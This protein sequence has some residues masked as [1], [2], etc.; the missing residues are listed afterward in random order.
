M[1]SIYTENKNGQFAL[2]NEMR[3]VWEQHVY[4]TRMLLISIAD[5]LGDLNA[6][7]ARLLRN[8]NDIAAIFARYYGPDAGRKIARL[9]TEHLQ[10]GAALITALRDGEKEKA[11]ALTRQWYENADKMAEAFSKLNPLY[12]YEQLRKMLY[13]HL[14][15]TTREVAMRLAANYP[16]DIEAF[17]A[18]EREALEMAD[19][20]TNG[21]SNMQPVQ[22]FGRAPMQRG[23]R[24]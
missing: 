1:I 24:R 20:F 19:Y 5:R 22:M 16:A 12:D 7:T 21:L 11:D 13:K 2:S 3:L 15:L 10:I 23:R 4:W 6:V 17:G 18:V 14:E 9:L 8:P